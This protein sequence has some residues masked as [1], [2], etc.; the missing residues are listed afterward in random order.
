M[1]PQRP[2]LVLAIGAALVL[3]ACDKQPAPATPETPAQAPAPKPQLGSFGFDAAGMD[4]S[5]AAGD[6]FF[7]FAN[8]G[9]HATAE[10]P[11][12]RSNWGA[13]AILAERAAARNH[14]IVQ[15]AAAGGLEGEDARKVGDHFAAFM[16][17]AAGFIARIAPLVTGAARRRRPVTRRLRPRARRH[18]WA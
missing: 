7:D 1:L 16:D 5:V 8:G 9:W 11:A 14:A 4:R 2:L 15:E 17:E 10:I 6:N 12:D 18:R 13:F 3:G